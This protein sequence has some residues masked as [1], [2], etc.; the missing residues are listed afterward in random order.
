MTGN[1][2]GLG[3]RPQRQY[4]HIQH[5]PSPHSPPP[6]HVAAC[7]A[8]SLSVL[9]PPLAQEPTPGVTAANVGAIAVADAG[10]VGAGRG[11]AM[12]PPISVT[13]GI[14]VGVGSSMVDNDGKFG[15][16]GAIIFSSK[17]VTGGNVVGVGATIVAADDGK[18][19]AT[20]AWMLHLSSSTGAPDTTS[21]AAGV[22]VPTATGDDVVDIMATGG[23]V[24]GEAVTG[25]KVTGEAVTGE[26]VTGKEVIGA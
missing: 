24:I 13:G 15:A 19:G 11:A 7:G 6:K 18:L 23:V 12:L 9:N 2:L 14:V 3:L 22:L 10:P 4:G 16:I 8:K 26:A 17:S 21:D 5:K 20:G 25:E 1:I